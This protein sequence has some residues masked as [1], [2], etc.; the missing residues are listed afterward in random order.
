M[1]I[2]IENFRVQRLTYSKAILAP[3]LE[4]IKKKKKHFAGQFLISF[5]KFWKTFIECWR[6]IAHS[7]IENSGS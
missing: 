4:F 7:C 6:P 3:N 2:F 1:D 5:V